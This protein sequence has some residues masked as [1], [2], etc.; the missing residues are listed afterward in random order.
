[1][2]EGD[3][4]SMRSMD[5][6]FHTDESQG[7]QSDDYDDPVLN[8]LASLPAEGTLASTLIVL[9]FI[10]GCFYGYEPDALITVVKSGRGRGPS[11]HFSDLGI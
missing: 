11:L 3:E 4:I 8:D 10:Q 6:S 5:D 9:P 7:C 1:M 2:D